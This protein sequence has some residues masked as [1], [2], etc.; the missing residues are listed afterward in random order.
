[1]DDG[2]DLN[3][4]PGKPVNRKQNPQPFQ[5]PRKRV[6][7]GYQRA[8]L[9]LLDF[10]EENGLRE[11]FLPLWEGRGPRHERLRAEWWLE[12]KQGFK[13]GFKEALAILGFT[14]L[15]YLLQFVLCTFMFNKLEPSLPAQY[16]GYFALFALFLPAITTLMY[17]EHLL[18]Q[19]S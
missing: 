1:M 2:I 11:D 5:K 6:K 15:L 3:A 17:M 7:Q 19:E 9:P 13:Q 8:G 16:M 4:L 10:L 18:H 12:F 14:F